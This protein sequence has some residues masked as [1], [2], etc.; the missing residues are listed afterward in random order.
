M[1]RV[2]LMAAAVVSLALLAGAQTS[3]AAPVGPVSTVEAASAAQHTLVKKVWWR[4]GVGYG[5]WGRGWRGGYG[6]WG[7]G[8]GGGYGGGYGG[9]GAGYGYGYPY[10]GAGVSACCAPP[11]PPCCVPPPCCGGYGGGYNGW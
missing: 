6:R 9:W 1:R 7:G 11:P 3:S 8:W 5:R 2:G 10:Y 4:G